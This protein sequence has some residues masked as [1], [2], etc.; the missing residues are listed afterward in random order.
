MARLSE[1]EE[2]YSKYSEDVPEKKAIPLNNK[3]RLKDILP[4]FKSPV[5][6]VGCA[7]GYDVDYFSKKGFKVAGCDLSKESIKIAQKNYPFSHFFTHDFTREKL[8]K[9]FM[10]IYSFDVIE[11]L[12]NYESFLKNLSFSL[13]SEGFLILTTPNVLGMKNRVKFVFGKGKYFETIPHIRFFD[14]HSLKRVLERNNFKVEKVIGH[15]YWPLPTTL[16]GNLTVI[17]KKS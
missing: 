7:K 6:D 10:T 9:K 14:A 8:N 17:A 5:L 4:F 12:F 3:N 2:Y 15:S 1:L 11:H 13:E 16:C